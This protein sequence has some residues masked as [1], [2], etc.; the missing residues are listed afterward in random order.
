MVRA[1]G[2][3]Q[4]REENGHSKTEL[5]VHMVR[6]GGYDTEPTARALVFLLINVDGGLVAMG[7][8]ARASDA[9]TTRCAGRDPGEGRRATSTVRGRSCINMTRV[10]WARGV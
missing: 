3:D 2:V 6:N 10:S 9:G 5:G 4:E 8:A 7:G 1:T